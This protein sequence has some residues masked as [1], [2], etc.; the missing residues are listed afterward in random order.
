MT[1]DNLFGTPPPP[2]KKRRT[3]SKPSTPAKARPK[4]SWFFALRPSQVDADRIYAAVAPLLSSH[5]VTGTRI[6][7]DRLHITLE[8]IGDDI[9]EDVISRACGAA[10]K[11]RLAPLD[12]SFTGIKT[13]PAPSG[14]CVLLGS[15]GLDSVR[16]LRSELVR[17]LAENG[18]KPP[19]SYEPHMTLC[20]D[21][22]HRV[23]RVPIEPIGFHAQEF[24]LV[25]SYLG[26][27]RHEVIR[28]WRL[29]R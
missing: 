13:F 14:P 7:A 8:W 15:E 24:A 17:T 4:F 18:F 21:R 22:V 12:A 23:A 16:K 10:D 29:E 26:Q 9:E 5:G 3:A 28:T 2:P 11:V 25:K 19:R 6:T 20:Y 27:S 1:Q